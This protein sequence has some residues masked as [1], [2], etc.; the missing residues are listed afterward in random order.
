MFLADILEWLRRSIWAAF[1]V[2]N[3]NIN[4]YERYRAVPDIP[5][6]HLEDSN[7]LRDKLSRLK[8]S[9]SIEWPNVRISPRS[10]DFGDSTT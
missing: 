10:S 7:Q 1:R 4:N 8:D 2:E 5:K 6:L 9:E 3:E